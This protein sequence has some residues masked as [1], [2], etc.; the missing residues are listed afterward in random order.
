MSNES[1]VAVLV[2]CDNTQPAILD[3]AMHCGAV[4]GRVVLK[5]AY[6]NH[7]T[8]ANR[9]KDC[10]VQMAFAPCLQFQHVA[11]KNTSDIALALDALEALLDQRADSFVVVTSDSDFV[12]LCHKL[13]E[14]GAAVHVVGEAKTPEALRHACDRFYEFVPA[15]AVKPVAQAQRHAPA[16]LVAV[17]AT[18][19]QV[20]K[21]QPQFVLDAVVKLAAATPDGKVHVSALGSHL[22]QLKP[23][24]SSKKFGYPKLTDMLRAYPSLELGVNGETASTVRLAKRKGQK[25]A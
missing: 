22:G 10:L 3:Y 24:F 17:P 16:P 20:A 6:G 14:R 9:W 15:D 25:A 12:Y 11:G 4:R 23:G 7:T 1:R 18:V 13:R 2:D 19:P 8:L 5:R 21:Q